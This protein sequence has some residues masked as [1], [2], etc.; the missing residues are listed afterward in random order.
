MAVAVGAT[1]CALALVVPPAGRTAPVDDIAVE[2]DWEPAAPTAGQPVTFRARV[3]PPDG[4]KIRELNWDLSGD[5]KAESFGEN[6][7]WTY[8][9][10]TTV[11]VRLRV[12]GNG[13]HRG[14][15]THKVS[16]AAAPGDP[17][18]APVA[19]FAAS[20]AA[21]TVGEPVLFTSGSSDPDGA[22][23]EQV[24]DLNGDASF[25]NGGGATALRTFPAAGEYVVGLRVTDNDG[26]VSFDSK[27]IWVDPGAAS[28]VPAATQKAGPRLMSPFPIVRISG[29][30][31]RS[32]TRV[33]VLSVSAPLGSTISVR[34]QGR[35]CPFKKQVRRTS[36]GLQSRTSVSLRVR[37]L[38]RLLLPGV[39][40]RVFVTKSGAIGK[41]TKFRFR[42]GK[43]PARTDRCLMPGSWTPAQCPA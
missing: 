3:N 29:R 35:R 21:P 27:T 2:F 32:G 4:V 40:V 43:P 17:R 20:P 8:S 26:L 19:S 28:G 39:R 9:A 42:S 24:W 36:P 6:P 7:T 41:Y 15:K 5:G 18:R 16:V 14:G 22:I 38:E 10:P 31:M 13:N 34:C 25:D 1:L 11:S 37:R 12:R 23:V 30:I 33:R